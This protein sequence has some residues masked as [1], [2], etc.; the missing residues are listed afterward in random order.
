MASGC[1]QSVP[2]PAA[3]VRYDSGMSEF[4]VIVV[5]GGHAGIE[6]TLASVRVGAR[7]CLVTF[8]RDGIGRMSCNPAIGGVAK[9]QIVREIDALGGAMGGL[10]DAAGIQFR[11]LN[12][13]KGAA[14]ISPRAQADKNL[15]QRYAQEVCEGT[16]GLTIV[17]G[18][19][20]HL[21]E[22]N[23]TRERA[24]LDSGSSSL[25][26]RSLTLRVQIGGVRLADGREL[27]APRVVL[28]TGTF[29]GGLLHYGEE[30]IVGGRAGEKASHGLGQQLRE[31]GFRTGRLKTGT[32]P[33]LDGTSIDWSRVEEQ[34]GDNPPRPFSF[35]TSR[36]DQ[37]QVSCFITYTN[38][39]THEVIRE[40]LSRSPLYSGQI[41]GVGPRYCPSI[42]DKIKR[43]PDKLS[44]HVFLEP[45]GLD[46]DEVYPNGISTSMP[47]DVQDAVVRTMV[48]LEDARILKY[49]YAVEYDFIP[50]TQIDSTLETKLVRGLYLAGQINGTTGY[51]EAGAQGLMA[52]LN[53]ALT[54]AG[55][56]PVVLRRDQGYIGVLIDDLTTHGTDEPY[57]MFTSL[58]E[59]RLRLRTDNADRRLTALAIE[60]GCVEPQRKARFMAKLNDY[61]RGEALLRTTRHDGKTLFDRLRTPQFEWATV[62]GLQPELID[63]DPEAMATLEI[64]AR[65]AG[66]MD[67]EDAEVARMGELEAVKL[68]PNLKY[69]GIEPLRKEAR[70]KLARIEPRTLGQAA[71]IPGIGPGDLTVLRVY[72]KSA[73]GVTS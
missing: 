45:E 40:N 54:L 62:C 69:A 56:S 12:T 65:Y 28:T 6:A 8:T 39:K 50:P 66:Y 59:Y 24:P 55:R 18:E 48:G 7:T 47:R 16:D 57:R 5:G 46:T 26:E 36:I 25:E 61:A 35:L 70:E 33:R 29:M 21:I 20:V 15:Y 38:E 51:E 22:Q 17:E 27:R 31:L 52:G 19:A 58:A 9:G 53:A 42:E 34:A 37:R 14:V 63:L 60:L 71:R 43:F 68:P 13:S 64:D 32:P 67:R 73:R 49:G 1:W 23:A 44:H 30:Q 41:V 4:D 72:L 11:M 3:Q 2:A 10:I